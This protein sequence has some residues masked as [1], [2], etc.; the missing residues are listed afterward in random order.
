MEKK[1][2]ILIFVVAFLL[3]SCKSKT[4]E[5]AEETNG[6]GKAVDLKV[7]IKDEPKAEEKEEIFALKTD[8]KRYNAGNGLYLTFKNNH[9]KDTKIRIGEGINLFKLEGD[10]VIDYGATKLACEC[11]KQCEP[12]VNNYDAP[13]KSTFSI[14]IMFN[15]GI[16][17]CSKGKKVNRELESG[18]YKV[19]VE[20]LDR[21]ETDVWRKIESNTFIVSK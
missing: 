17:V 16:E 3:I 7:E 15:L 19:G 4:I 10:S 6:V 13:T 18:V 9:E 14:P 21:G 20:Y 12:K 5:I 2:L 11:D 1:I 8:K